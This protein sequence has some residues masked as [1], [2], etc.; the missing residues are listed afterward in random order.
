MAKILLVVVFSN[1]LTAR[2]SALSK[3]LLHTIAKVDVAFTA[4][5]VVVVVSKRRR[6]AL[7]V[8]LFRVKVT[9]HNTHTHSY[10][11]TDTNRLFH[12]A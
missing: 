11:H 9:K 6:A 10:T 4:V 12:R 2:Q 8:E 1:T 5:S 3:R 7:R